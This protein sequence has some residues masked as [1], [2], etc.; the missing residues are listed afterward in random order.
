MPIYGTHER[1]CILGNE[2][3]PCLSGQ[4]GVDIGWRDMKSCSQFSFSNSFGEVKAPNSPHVFVAQFRRSIL[5]ASQVFGMIC[6]TL[7]DHVT[8]VRHLISK[9]QMGVIATRGI[10]ARMTYKLSPWIDS[11]CK[12]PCNSVSQIEGISKPYLAIARWSF[13]PEPIPAGIGAACSDAGPKMFYFCWRQFWQRKNTLHESKY[14]VSK[15]NVQM[16]CNR[17]EK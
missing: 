13:V 5:R 7:N 11:C 14:T 9:K 2:M 3:L 16:R 6:S 1:D 15:C 12:K 10:I 4:N 8:H 17:V